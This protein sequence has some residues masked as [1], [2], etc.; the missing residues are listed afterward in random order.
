MELSGPPPQGYKLAH[1][2]KIYEAIVD[3]SRPLRML[4]ISSFYDASL[5][6]WHE[7][8]HPDSQIINVDTDSRLLKIRDSGGICVH[9]CEGKNG[10]FL[11]QVAAEFG[12]FDVILDNGS[13]GSSRMVSSFRC[14][15]ATALKDEGIYIAEDVYRDYWKR[16]RDS[17]VSFMDLVRALADAM[18]GHYQVATSETNFQV[19][20]PDRIREVSVPSIT[21][22]LGGIEIHD[23]IVIVRRT[24]RDLTRMQTGA[25]R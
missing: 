23:S 24:C 2:S 17:R 25:R 6:T 4:L 12:P 8:L 5:Q 1:Y 22:I 9:F 10:S 20:H 21:P 15:F 19:G 18:H 13:H 3:R 16:Y 14:L 11:A 7:F